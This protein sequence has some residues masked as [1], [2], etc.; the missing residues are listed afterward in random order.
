MAIKRLVVPAAEKFAE[1]L[2]QKFEDKSVGATAGKNFD[3]IVRLRDG[4]PAE[5]LAFV[6]RD[7]SKLFKPASWSTPAKGAKYDLSTDEG[8]AS[9]VALADT[10]GRYLYSNFNPLTGLRANSIG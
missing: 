4:V 6:E 9:T 3:K 1:A 7:T 5:V 2:D 8:F 10:F